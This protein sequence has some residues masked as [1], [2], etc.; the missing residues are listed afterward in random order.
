MQYLVRMYV[1]RYEKEDAGTDK[2]KLPIP[3]PSDITQAS[4]VNFDDIYKEMA[5]IRKDFE[6]ERTYLF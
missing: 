1:F 6:S 3:D 2:V 4:L 5:R